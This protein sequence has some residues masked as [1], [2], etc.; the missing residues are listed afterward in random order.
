MPNQE[1]IYGLEW[2]LTLAAMDMGPFKRVI[3]KSNLSKTV[4][5]RLMK[6][7]NIEISAGDSVTRSPA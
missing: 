6:R 3:L 5:G 7:K 1:T 2:H 4:S